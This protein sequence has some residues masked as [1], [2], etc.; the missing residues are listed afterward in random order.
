[1]LGQHVTTLFDGIADEGEMKFTFDGQRMSSGA[2]VVVMQT[3]SSI[4]NHKILLLK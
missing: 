2:Y 4:I 1:M 3:E